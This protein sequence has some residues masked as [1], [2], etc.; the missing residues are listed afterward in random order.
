MVDVLERSIQEKFDDLTE[1]SVMKDADVKSQE[2]VVSKCL[3]DSLVVVVMPKS[4]T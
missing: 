4:I 1:G 2:V 3:T